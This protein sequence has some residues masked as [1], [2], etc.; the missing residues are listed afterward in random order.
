M[1]YGHILPFLGRICL[2]KDREILEFT[3]DG[4]HNGSP[5]STDSTHISS[6]KV[7]GGLL[8]FVSL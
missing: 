6:N 3:N 1:R 7:T 4:N 8:I 5:N 2:S